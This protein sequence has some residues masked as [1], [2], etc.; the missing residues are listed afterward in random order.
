[1]SKMLYSFIMLVLAPATVVCGYLFIDE[2]KYYFISLLLIAYTMVP[3]FVGFEKKRLQAR[4][5][6]IIA[7]MVALGTVGR[8]AFFM[9]PNFKPC[10]A[11][12]IISGIALGRESGFLVGALTAFVSNFLFGQGP[13]T[14]WQ[15]FAMG[16]V[17]YL[18]G[19]LA[20]KHLLGKKKL[21]ILVFG[22]FCGFILYGLIVDVWT[23]LAM[24][25]IP[26]WQTAAIVY[27]AALPIN[28]IHG[29]AT[30]VFLFFLAMPL[31]EKINRVKEKY[32]M[33]VFA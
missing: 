12:I 11:V 26:T 33:N 17:G 7:I 16:I 4:E 1:M 23:I 19:Y 32:G 30:V 15:M 28:A 10:L 5:L 25:P 14:P 18:A 8:A 2:R 20:E 6:I 24:T 21:P 27:G 9:L 13:W 3:F 31:I 22:G 29:L